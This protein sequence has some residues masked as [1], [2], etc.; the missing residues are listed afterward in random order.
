MTTSGPNQCRSCKHLQSGP[1]VT[2]YGTPWTCA[3]YPAPREIPGE[4]SYGGLDHRELR[5]DERGDIKFELKPD[6]D[7]AAAM[8][9]TW[10]R[11]YD[12]VV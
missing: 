12:A 9:E 4:I 11:I 7:Y 3:A 8:F 5:G 1:P 2:G 6:D 10:E